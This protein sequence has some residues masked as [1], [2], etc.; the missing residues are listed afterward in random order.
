MTEEIDTPAASADACISVIYSRT[1]IDHATHPRNPGPIDQHD[2]Y[3]VITGPCSDTM[4]I[5]LRVRNDLIIAATFMT[6]GCGPSIASGS[7]ATELA[8]GKKIADAIRITQEDIL[9]ALGGLPE[10]SRHCALLA[11]NTLKAAIRDYI[12]FRNEPWKR[13]YKKY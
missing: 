10:D 3:A 5:W 7:V 2:G 8:T 1:T 6:D 13:A 11:A 4:Q 12:A 9:E